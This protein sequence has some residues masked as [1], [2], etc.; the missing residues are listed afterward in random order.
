MNSISI[1]AASADA[2]RPGRRVFLRTGGAGALLLAGLKPAAA[3]DYPQREISV[4]VPYSPG[5][6]GDLFA[7]VLSDP[8]AAL[9]GQSVIVENRPGATGMLGTRRVVRDKPDGYSILMGQTGEIAIIPSANKAAGYDTLRDLAPVVLVGDSPLVMIAP[10]KAPFDTVQ[11]LVAYARNKSGQLAYASSGTAT[12]GHLAAAALALGTKTEMIHVPY[13]GA[14]QA[15]TDVIGGQ[16][17]FFFSSASAAM[18][19]IKAGSVKAL[20]VASLA[21]M[22]SLPDVPTVNETVLEG[23]NYSLWGGFFAPRATPAE[24]VELLNQKI[25]ALL[26]HPDIRGRFEADGAIVQANSSAQFTDFVRTEIAKYSDLLRTTGVTI[27]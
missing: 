13:K 8:L 23:F 11:E 27:G 3:Q 9:L 1:F 14:G 16:V 20:A 17:S 5:G 15:M 12:P 2:C 26:A 18:G 19:H 6:Q 24:V 21:R 7:R 10:Q 22:P 25:N 4:T